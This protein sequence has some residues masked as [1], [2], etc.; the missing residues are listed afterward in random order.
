MHLGGSL[1]LRQ[2]GYWVIHFE[3][4]SLLQSEEIIVS[5]LERA[6]VW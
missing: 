5:Y 4:L 1:Y 2:K 3:N 6:I